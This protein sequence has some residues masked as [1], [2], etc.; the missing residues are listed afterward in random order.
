ML[1]RSLNSGRTTRFYNKEG[2]KG[3]RRGVK[4]TRRAHR[5]LE[6]QRKMLWTNEAE[7]NSWIRI[8]RRFVFRATQLQTQQRLNLTLCGLN[9]E[10]FAWQK[11]EYESS[12]GATT[13]TFALY[14][15]DS[16]I[17]YQL[18]F[19]LT[20]GERESGLFVKARD[21]SYSYK[22]W[23]DGTAKAHADFLYI[24]LLWSL[25]VNLLWGVKNW[26]KLG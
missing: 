24:T 12:A 18:A 19:I 2:K 11:E 13:L 25:T 6:V 17:T 3:E 23:S 14:A 16:H 26:N 9:C 10:S 22:Y 8:Y 21:I 20:S 4:R 5:T 15:A 1:W 7:I